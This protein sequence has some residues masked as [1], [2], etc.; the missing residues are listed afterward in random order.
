MRRGGGALAKFRGGRLT[1]RPGWTQPVTTLQRLC[2]GT[3]NSPIF[4]SIKPFPA[5]P[6]GNISSMHDTNHKGN[7]AEAAI[8]A[9]ATKL[10]IPVLKPLVEHTRYDLVFEV[11]DSLFR[12]Q[13]KW[14]PLR[15]DVVVVNLMSACY[16]SGGRQIRRPYTAA[17]IDA[18]AVYCQALDECYLVTAEMFDGRRGLHLRVGP[19]RNGQ[20]AQLNWAA[21]YR[22]SGAVAQLG[23]ACGWQPQGRGFESHQL[24]S[25]IGI[26]Q[27]VVGAHD[28]RR[29]FGWYMQRSAP[30]EEFLVT[31]RGKPYV[32]LLPA[33]EQ[34]ALN[35]GERNGGPAGP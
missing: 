18:V 7:V 20:L 21:D 32:R 30:G 26:E 25:S 2:T 19:P 11:D 4:G 27:A 16:T 28:F 14:A 24:H 33:P 22:L 8:A 34:L 5:D 6:Y 3:V 13:C 15:E 23:R 10:G 12:I 29:R 1:G 17:E 35:G 31:R 9:E